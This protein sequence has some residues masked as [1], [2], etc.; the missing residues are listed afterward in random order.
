[1]FIR[2]GKIVGGNNNILYII[3]DYKD[4]LASYIISFYQ[5][6][7]IPN[8]IIINENINAEV[9]SDFTKVKVYSPERG[10]KKKL[11]EMATLN[12]KIAAENEIELLHLK[13]EKTLGAHT[14]L[15]ELLNLN[16]RR[17]DAFDNSNLF[18]SYCVSGMVVFENGKPNKNEYRKYKISLEKNDDYN[19]MKEV[20]FR[21]YNRAT[22]EKSI[23]PELII[24]DGGINQ[25]NAAKEVLKSIDV[26]IKVVGLKKDDKHS[27]KALIDGDT[28]KEIDLSTEH[29]VF[30]Y[31][32]KIQDEVHRFTIN[33]H[34][35]IRSKGSIAS[36]L[37]NIEG[38]GS[39]RKKELIKKYGSV[40]KI[41]E[42]SIDELN[43]LLPPS[44]S[45]NLFN[46]LK[47][48]NN[49]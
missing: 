19:T 2:N 44:V 41:S 7:E 23:L 42:A 8:E 43:S 10:K 18:G 25:I 4:E 11:V 33:Y 48:W 29:N 16:I 39:V 9:I 26:F 38:I 34:K 45:Y 24:V 49:K 36:V 27:T 3:S 21:R 13:E 40:K 15:G 22:I 37:D 47:E 1:M 12:A 35:Q 20:V 28:L 5:N 17:I 31:L 32:T 46:Y 14:R 6:H 30:L